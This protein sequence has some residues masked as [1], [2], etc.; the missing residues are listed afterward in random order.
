VCHL[1]GITDAA[2]L[3]THPLRGAIFESWVAAEI[4]KAHVHRR[5]TPQLFHFRE[6]RGSEVDLGVAHGR[7]MTLV[8][9]KS[10]ATVSGDYFTG[11]HA[12]AADLLRG[13]HV[14]EVTSAVVFGGDA[15]QRRSD[16]TVV[17]WSAV[18]ERDWRR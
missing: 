9:A 16:V 2:Q 1:L 14:D 10:G 11:L 18:A 13:R 8:E 12:V 15:S 4:W 5:E 17:S 7:R 6:T 3:T